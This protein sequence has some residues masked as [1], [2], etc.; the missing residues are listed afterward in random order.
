MLEVDGCA[1]A[2]MASPRPATGAEDGVSS[3]T[4]WGAV[5]KFSFNI[6][7]IDPIAVGADAL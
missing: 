7:P 4:G 2:F 6:L 5:R 3:V 1:V